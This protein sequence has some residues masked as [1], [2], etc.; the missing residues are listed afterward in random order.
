MR[1]EPVSEKPSKNAIGLLRLLLIGSVV[2][3]ATLFVTASWLSYRAAFRDARLELERSS[4]VAREHAAKIFNN[5]TLIADRI[6][7]L[8]RDLDA[9]AIRRKEL[10][11]NEEFVRLDERFPEIQ[12][13]LLID[14]IGHLLVSSAVYPV[15]SD[16]DLSSRDYFKAVVDERAGLYVGRLQQGYL[17]GRAFFGIGRPWHSSD[18]M[19]RGVIA[20]AIAPAFFEE[21]YRVL[22]GQ[23]LDA[24]EDK[25]A[26]LV[27]EDGQILVR[28]PPV[29]GPPPRAPASGPFLTAI[30]ANSERGFYQ[31]RSIVGSNPPERLYAYAK[32]PDLPIYAVAGIDRE[33]IVAG[34]RMTM[35]SH[36]IFGLPA[37]IALFT[38]TRIAL[39]RTRREEQ[40][41]A[42]AHEE[43]RMR[44]QAEA[45][46]LHA[47]RLDAVGQLTGGIAHDFNNLLTVILGGAEMLRRRPADASAVQAQA[48]RIT[49]AVQR[50]SDITR[51]LL[52]F[53]RRQIVHPE[54]IDP[55]TRLE[56]FKPLLDQAAQESV[57]VSLDLGSSIG[58]IQVDPGQFEAA[59]LNLVGNARDAMPQGGGIVIATRSIY[60]KGGGELTPGSY[61]CVTVTDSGTGME[62]TTVARAFE[63]FF[64]TKEIGK[65]TGLGLSQVYG[66]AKQA[67]GEVRITSS[68]GTGTTV[69]LTLPRAIGNQLPV[70]EPAREFSAETRKGAV[71]LVVED[72]PD[73]L[74]TAVE[75]L[76]DLS[77]EVI[78]ATSGALALDSIRSAPKVDIL[79][80][81]I[82]M[83]GGMDGVQLSIEAQRLRPDL[84]ILL[85]S[86][87]FEVSG[88]E[89]ANEPSIM[90]K[91]YTKAEL[92]ARLASLSNRPSG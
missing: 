68:V 45:T 49:L 14:R 75:M 7:D 55:N 44:E 32:I 11:L 36:L 90:L 31:S 9:A 17:L 4:Q 62:P 60:W 38:I 85:T 6:N 70:R 89:Q 10:S 23:D 71:V 30:R 81:D 67:G 54:V 2:L 41:L 21:F 16:V 1:R 40:A 42:R 43:V 77:C 26:T 12:N 46:L 29:S 24:A 48:E 35:A 28:Y 39:V 72:D 3:P 25:V 57:Q 88:H 19:L 63:P 59:L 84:Q 65:G 8:V 37:T 20:V 86:G 82:K 33:I 22:I 13:I 79:F 5:Q 64:T 66:F 87:Y 47:Q 52:A 92:A 50:G 76:K 15:P 27:R 56:Q 34:W 69:E 61:V 74:H 58:L 53:S 73:V 83:P 51:Q 18:G 78:T 91:P 80:S